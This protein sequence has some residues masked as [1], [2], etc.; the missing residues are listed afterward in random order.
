MAKLKANVFLK[1]ARLIE[2]QLGKQYNGDDGYMG[3]CE[4]IK[5]ATGHYGQSDEFLFFKKMFAP[6]RK[7]YL[8]WFGTPYSNSP[9]PLHLSSE[10]LKPNRKNQRKRINALKKAYKAAMKHNKRLK[11]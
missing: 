5:N 1:A 2:K 6:R 10:V 7:S 8:W 9:L 3:C 11:K 4:A